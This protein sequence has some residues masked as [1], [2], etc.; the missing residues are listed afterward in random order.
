MTYERLGDVMLILAA[1]LLCVLTVTVYRKRVINIGSLFVAYE[2]SEEK[3]PAVF[4]TCFVLQFLATAL[5]CL[6][7]VVHLSK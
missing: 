6:L 7:C 2:L 4:W 5:L 1:S 3:S